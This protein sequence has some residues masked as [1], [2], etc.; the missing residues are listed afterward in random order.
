MK[1][2]SKEEMK[3]IKGG[4]TH[5]GTCSANSATCQSFPSG[6]VCTNLYGYGGLAMQCAN[7]STMEVEFDSC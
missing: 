7:F 3:Q 2:L 5:C 4:T 6:W 1:Q